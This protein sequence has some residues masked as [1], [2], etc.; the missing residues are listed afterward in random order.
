MVDDVV[1]YE[2]MKLRL[3]NAS[4]QGLAHW[5][6]LLGIKY[7]HEAAADADIATWVRAYLEREARATLRSVPGIDLDDY[8]STLFKR[9]TNEAI[10]DTLFRLAQD[11]S[12]R[13]PKFVLGTVRDNL[14]AGGPIRLGTA[15][16]AAWALGSEGHDENGG[17]GR[18]VGFAL[19]GVRGLGTLRASRRTALA[20]DP[21][22]GLLELLGLDEDVAG[23]GPL[24]G[25]DDLTGLEQV[26][27]ASG[28]G[29]ADAQL[30]LEHG[31]GAELTGDDELG[32]LQEQVHVVADLLVNLL[33]DLRDDDVL[34]V[35]GRQ[36]GL[37]V[38]DDG[39]D[40]GLGDPR[41]LDT[42]WCGGARPQVEGVTLAGERLGPVLVEDDPG[43]QLRGRGEGQARGDGGLDEAG[44]GRPAE[45]L[46][47]STEF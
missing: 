2:L 34:A 21:G 38:L 46:F 25:A 17:G 9:F 6:R 3:L 24:R 29:E 19:R 8:I 28:L 42:H 18:G 41:A 33:L 31:G 4:H 13:M 12:S 16:V 14:T 30:A 15:M 43:V 40:L 37:D 32:G 20:L 10:A 45:G 27:E 36:L 5:G 7:A 26:H 39:T 22:Q 11:A 47:G 35:L 23:L 44:G 1:P